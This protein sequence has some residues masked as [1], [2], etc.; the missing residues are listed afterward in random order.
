MRGQDEVAGWIALRSAHGVGDVAARRLLAH[1]GSVR[2]VLS[3]SEPALVAAGLNEAVARAVRAARQGERQAADEVARLAAIGARVIPCTDDEYPS[4]LAQLPDAPL[5]LV[6]RGER[7]LDAPAVAVVGARHATPYGK[8]VASRFAEELAQ[9]GVTV[10]S[11]LARGIDGAAHAGALRGGGHTVAVLGCG[12]DV[13][14]PPEHTELTAAIVASGTLLSERPLGTPPLAE[15]FPA[16]NRIIAGMTHGTLVVEAAEH[17]GSQITA[18]LALDQGREVFAVPGRIDSPLSV[19]THRLIQQGAKLVGS[20]DDVLAEIVPAL[21]ARGFA[22]APSA[23]D[24]TSWRGDA[25]P[26]QDDALVPLLTAGPLAADEL[27]RQS[28]LPAAQV[29]TRILE[30]ELRG[31]LMQLPGKQFQ[32]THR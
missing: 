20:V 16:R 5:Y 27:I 25:R 32:L 29:L 28:G 2:A 1:F 14:Y 6:A 15:H 11:G 4:L 19:G 30:L 3:A 10:V 12:I 17:S 24:A 9:A 22:T 13:V 31:V 8:D 18:R 23:S 7:L 21:R 26:I